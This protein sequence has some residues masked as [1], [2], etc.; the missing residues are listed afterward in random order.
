MAQS[1]IGVI[2]DGEFA[3]RL[4]TTKMSD[5]K[6]T[7]MNFE[8]CSSSD[9]N[10]EDSFIFDEDSFANALTSARLL[11]K[12]ENEDYNNDDNYENDEYINENNDEY[13]N[14][15]NNENNDDNEDIYIRIANTSTQSS[16]LTPCAVLDIFEGNIRRCGGKT[17]LWALKQMIGTWEIDGDAI[18]EI[19]NSYHQLG[20]CFSHFTFDQNRLHTEAGRWLFVRKTGI[21]GKILSCK[22]AEKHHN[23]TSNA[24]KYIGK[25]IM[26][27][28]E[29][30]DQILQERLLS[31]V[32]S[33]LTI[34]NNELMSKNLTSTEKEPEKLPSKLLVLMALKMR[35]ASIVGEN[36]GKNILSL[37]SEIQK[38]ISQLEK[39]SFYE[40][41]FNALPKTISRVISYT[42][43]HENRLENFRMH[44]ANPRENLIK[45]L[46][47]WNLSAINNIDFK[48]STFLQ[49]NIFDILTMMLKI[50]ADQSENNRLSTLLAEYTDDVVASQSDK[51]DKEKKTNNQVDSLPLASI[52]QESISSTL[53]QTPLPFETDQLSEATI[54]NVL[55]QLNAVSS[56]W[57]NERVKIFWRNNR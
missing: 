23:D 14:K 16:L 50:K 53:Q 38:N 29:S 56:D 57:T 5:S 12:K 13:N 42:K 48:A 52:I 27:V 25:W 26:S 7:Y 8:E 15:N 28:A 36:L 46:N 9:E 1:K 19:K 43:R 41:Y 49:V 40:D 54:S 22:E 6:F 51:E 31:L 11:L 35:K 4:T 17:N 55:L 3:L 37:Y 45:K 34:F 30:D 32:T 39:P 20:V 2:E 18:K 10:Q 44:H 47:I 33:A 21:G 24:L